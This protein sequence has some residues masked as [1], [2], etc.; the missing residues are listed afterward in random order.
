MSSSSASF[1]E[2]EEPIYSGLQEA[3]TPFKAHPAVAPANAK[4]IALLVLGM[5]RSG[6]SSLAGTLVKLGAKAPNTPLPAS[7]DNERGFFESLPIMQLND[8]IL[9]SAGSS[10]DDWRAFNRGWSTSGVAAEFEQRAVATLV[11]EFGTAP[12]VLIKD[13]RLCRM[14]PF[15]SKVFDQAGYEIRVL[16][17]VRSPLE[18]ARS[19]WLRN[20]F[21]ISKGLL[22][23][24]RHVLDAE[25]A[26]RQQPRA[27]LDW[28][29]FLAD[30]RLAMT[31]VEKRLQLSWPSE[32]DQSVAEIDRFLSPGLRH[33]AVDFEDL[34]IHKD[35]NQWVLSAYKAMIAL[36][37]DSTS[38][39][40]RH[41][42]DEVRTEFDKA[43]NIFGRAL[44]DFE[45]NVTQWRKQSEVAKLERDAAQSE[46][47]RQI[48]EA[49]R[50][51]QQAEHLASELGRA[52]SEAN[53]LRIAAEALAANRDALAHERDRLT[54]EAA[55]LR[56]HVGQ[57][58]AEREAL[59]RERDSLLALPSQ[60]SADI[61]PE[62][63]E[64]SA[65]PE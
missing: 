51:H 32:S 49:A 14:M 34:V 57:L 46:R 18:V 59:V 61:Q 15:W 26:S 45:E 42:L 35:V 9:A 48:E 2:I 60:H 55:A 4:N 20:G 22:M 27:V 50:H 25:G 31:R 6:T 29:E 39:N 44:V 21:P 28:S 13:P 16:M 7:S 56:L 5:H 33:N 52:G 17:P 47:D 65:Q 36:S 12:L 23:W 10:W 54:A 37:V 38:S 58:A 8:E 53:E 63:P 24:L 11:A 41:T 62:T 19:L 64:V 40:A 1:M 43:S 3:V 30:W